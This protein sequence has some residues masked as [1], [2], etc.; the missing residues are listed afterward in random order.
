[1]GQ[2]LDGNTPGTKSHHDT[3]AQPQ[4]LE[5]CGSATNTAPG[6]VTSEAT[7]PLQITQWELVLMWV[8][9]LV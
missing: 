3:S 7:L 2:G 6:L 5:R 4:H 9:P 1:M 8:C